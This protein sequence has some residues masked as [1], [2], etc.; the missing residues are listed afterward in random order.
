MENISISDE[1]DLLEANMA[2]VTLQEAEPNFVPEPELPEIDKIK[3]QIQINKLEN[4]IL[5]K[6]MPKESSK[7]DN[8]AIAEEK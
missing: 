1:F 8:A 2:A 4:K 6:I 3:P 5:I 7:A